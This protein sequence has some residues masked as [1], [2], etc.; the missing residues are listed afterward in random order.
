M[1]TRAIFS[2]VGGRGSTQSA[3]HDQQ[4]VV[5]VIIDIGFPGPDRGEGGKCSFVPPDYDGPL[6]DSGFHVGHPRTNHVL[7]AVRAFMDNNNPK[8]S[9][10]LIKNAEIPMAPRRTGCRRR[11]T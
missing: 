10:E 9:A 8:P 3:R 4:H 6:P 11:T 2:A 5:R 1:M 7:N